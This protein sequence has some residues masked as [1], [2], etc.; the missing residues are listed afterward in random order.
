MIFHQ[1]VSATVGPKQQE[2]FYSL[3]GNSEKKNY[4]NKKQ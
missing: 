4:W 2:D 1:N 3:I